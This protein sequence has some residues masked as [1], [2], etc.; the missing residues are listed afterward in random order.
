MFPVYALSTVLMIAYAAIFTLLSEMRISFGFSETAIGAIAGSAFLAGFLAQLSLA[1]FADRGFGQQIMQFGI[2]CSLVGAIWMCF[3]ESLWAW[4]AARTILGFGAGCMRP[5]VRRLAFV[6]D[7]DKAGENLGRLAAWEMVGFLIGPVLS[8]VLFELG[9]IRAPFYLVVIL[10][11]VLVPFVVKVQIPGTNSQH[12]TGMRELIKRPAMQS[13]IAIGI[14]FFVAV[15]VFDAIWAVF[16]ADLGASQLFIGVSMSLFTLPM[17]LI[18][19]AAGRLAARKHVLR[20][21]TLTLCGAAIMMFSYGF[22]D[23]IWWICVPL[24]IHA[25]LDAMSMPAMQLAVGYASG[26]DAL[27]TGQGL[28]GG[29]SLLVGAAASLLSGWVYQ[30][31]GAEGLWSGVTVTMFLLI[32]F[33]RWRGSYGNWEAQVLK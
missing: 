8:S 24:L 2:V 20:L 3:A 17:I 32:A 27:A 6:I 11:L 29:I 18:A 25:S 4:L 14:A 21:L 1:R 23:S 9:G 19:P 31:W 26:E 7:P 10:L 5:A 28:Y 22:I 30:Y 13:C 33:A 12:S 16:I 15:G